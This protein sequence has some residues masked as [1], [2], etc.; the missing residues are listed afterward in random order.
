MKSIFISLIAS[1][2]LAG[3]VVHNGV[4]SDQAGVA[5]PKGAPVNELNSMRK[6]SGY[7]SALVAGNAYEVTYSGPW[8]GS[9]DALEGRFLYRAALLA[10]EHGSTSFRFLHMPGEG[11]PLSHPSRSSPAFGFAYGH[12]Q[13]HWSYR[14]DEG[15]QPWHPEWGDRFWADRLASNAV[16]Q[17]EVHAMIEL[18]PGAIGRGEQMDFEVLAVLRDLRPFKSAQRH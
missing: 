4:A 16:G 9:R 8:A 11:G 17:V 15:W 1:G 12:W 3:C 10:R 5:I 18:R 7:A 2:T 6:P 14:T 13:P